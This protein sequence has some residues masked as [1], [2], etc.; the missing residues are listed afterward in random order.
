MHTAK[1]SVQD[2][3]DIGRKRYIMG[4]F[5]KS[6]IWDYTILTCVLQ[7]KP[8]AFFHQ[9]Q[10]LL[11]I[12]YCKVYCIL[13]FLL[14]KFLSLLSLTTFHSVILRANVVWQ[15]SPGYIQVTFRLLIFCQRLCHRT[16]FWVALAG[17]TSGNSNE[18]FHLFLSF[19]FNIPFMLRYSTWTFWLQM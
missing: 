15:S 2:S 17:N 1:A 11:S 16:V 3:G 18:Q 9:V 7:F 19:F 5:H 13:I 10:T 6:A 14:W 4:T 8:N 12:H